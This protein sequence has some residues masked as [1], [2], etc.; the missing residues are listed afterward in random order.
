MQTRKSQDLAISCLASRPKLGMRQGLDC[1]RDVAK[2]VLATVNFGSTARHHDRQGSNP[3]SSEAVMLQVE[4]LL[5][6]L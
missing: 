3:I 1:Q 2:T 4:V 6:F 5:R